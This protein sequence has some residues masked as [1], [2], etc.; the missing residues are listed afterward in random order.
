MDK[1]GSAT[2]LKRTKKL[3][4]RYD[5]RAR[6][7]LAQHFLVDDAV[8]DK[9]LK[10]ADLKSD[11]TVIEVGPGL[12]LMTAELA[13][14]AGWVIAIELDNRLASI[15]QKTLQ[16]ENVVILN[17][18]VLGTDPAKLLKGGAPHFPPS[19]SSY[20]V[21]A[22]LPY[23]ITSPVLRHFLEAKVKPDVMVV[24]VQKEVA[25]I[26]CAEAGQRSLLSIAVQFYGK[27][28]IVTD[29]P[30]AS[31][32]PP[33]EVDSA[34]VRIDVYAKP[35]VPVTDTSGFFRLVRAGF[36]AARKQAANSLAQGL[37]LPKEKVLALLDK[38]SIDP[39]RRAET[40]TLEEWAALFKEYNLK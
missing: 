10:T 13:K 34:V 15:L 6:K 14:R 22:N 31:F 11:D 33:P 4:R 28:G 40:F 23:Y 36:S 18:D 1:T 24:M 16:H 17:E 26:I 5:I 8:L 2:L 20:K 3:L 19:L 39:R 9:I 27:P 37:G 25:Q 35:P 32:Y 29:V 21:V 38:A 7:G 30:A 12:G